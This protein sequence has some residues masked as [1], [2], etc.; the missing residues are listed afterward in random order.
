MNPLIVLRILPAI[1][2]SF[3]LCI[4]GCTTYGGSVPVDDTGGFEGESGVRDGASIPVDENGGLMPD[5]PAKAGEIKG[6][7]KLD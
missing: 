5:G 7:Q 1:L 4:T 6:A 3:A 2:L